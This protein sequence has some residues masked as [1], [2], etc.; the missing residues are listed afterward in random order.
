MKHLL[1]LALLITLISSNLFSQQYQRDTRIQILKEDGNNLYK[2]DQITDI[3][4]LQALELSG[5]S[6][7]KFQIGSFDKKYNLLI[8]IDEYKDYK[9]VKSD[10]LFNDTN[11]YI[12]FRT[13]EKE[14]F[15][16]YIDQ[17]KIISKTQDTVLTFQF[18]TYG[19]RFKK[20]IHHKKYDKESFYNFRT[21]SNTRWELNVKIPLLVY[22]SSW[23]DKQ[24]GFQ[25]FCGVVDLSSNIEKTNELLNS[26]PHYY[27]ISYLIQ[28]LKD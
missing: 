14:Y 1:L 15:K 20:E 6:I 23:K 10:T 13:G 27:S 5:I 4:L 19:V 8:L 16:D 2:S 28:E 17:I 25:R 3:D 22:A 7:N 12:Y 11:E 24:Y 21:Y 9:I 18:I 26:S